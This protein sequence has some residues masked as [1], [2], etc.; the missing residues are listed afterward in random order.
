M[1]VEAWIAVAVVV[2]VFV[3]LAWGLFPPYLTLLAGMTALLVAGIIDPSQ[4]LEGF[5]NSGV[6]TVGVLF[7]V[8]AGL[9]QSGAL[10]F[11]VSRALGRPRTVR[12]AQVRMLLPTTIGSAFLN[13]TPLVAMLLPVVMDW[14]RSMRIPASKM[15]LPL[16]YAAILG[17][18]C[19]LVGTSTTLV[20]N[21]LLIQDGKP[22]MGMFDITWIGLPCAALGS[23]LLM[24]TARRWLPAYEGVSLV[25]PDPREYTVEMRVAQRGPVGGKSIEDA[26]LRHLP[27]LY[28]MEIHRDGHILPVV[29]PAE[30]LEPGDQLVFVGVVDSIVD[31]QQI[32]GLEPISQQV[33]KLDSH[34]SLRCFA[35]AVVSRTHPLVGQSIR[36]GQFRRRYNA[37]VIAVSRNGERVHGRIGDIKLRVGDSLLL[38][39]LPSFVEQHR[40]SSDFYL[41]SRMGDAGPPTTAQAPIALLILAG[42]VTAVATGFLSMLQAA[43][44]A[45]MAMLLARCC[46][47]ETARRSIDWPLIVAIASSF[48][49]GRAL[50]TTGAA[51]TL[52]G[53]LLSQAGNHP[54]LALAALYA[55]TTLMTEF[56]TNNAA[57]VIVFPIAMATASSLQ[58]NYVPFVMAVAV[59]ASASFASPIGYQTNLMVY[60]P[61]GYKLTDFLKMGVPMN[62]L[63]GAVTTGLAP[64]IWPF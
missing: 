63:L 57:A 17:G 15:L 58:V 45:A 19:T 55:T 62:L 39:T 60:G 9:K 10:T 61:G 25:P 18:L 46:S 12:A 13:N 16:S 43:L 24:W 49:L 6:V 36:E 32:P 23:A 31:L 5:S 7:V 59:A 26:G 33:F 38:E 4:A 29:D 47:E 56:V 1:S 51:A 40:N 27:G 22:P 53:V 28:L 52:S 37:V 3:L 8:A 30:P 64:L 11:L 14:C 2:A 48:G 34:R 54:W 35:E 41:V 50:E 44:L 21:G 20:V 42:M